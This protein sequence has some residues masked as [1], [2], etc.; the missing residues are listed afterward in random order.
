MTITPGSV[1]IADDG[2][3]TKTGLAEAIYDAFVDNFLADTDTTPPLGGVAMPAGSDGAAIKRGFAVNATRLAE[4]LA[5][6]TGGIDYVAAVQA[7]DLTLTS[8][9]PATD[10]TDL[11][12][13][14]GVGTWVVEMHAHYTCG[15]ASTDGYRADWTFSGTETAVRR[16]FMGGRAAATDAAINSQTSTDLATD[17][18]IVGEA[19]LPFFTIDKLTI[20]VSVSGTL[21]FRAAKNADAG[22]DTTFNANSYLIARRLI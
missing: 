20:V 14:L 5:T 18:V 16:W 22:A 19:A 6:P 9:N 15:A 17:L 1:S 8:T 7:A 10:A 12:V 11:S 2:G 13:T 3:E 4:S 21:T